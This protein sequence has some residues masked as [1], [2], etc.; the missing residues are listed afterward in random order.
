MPAP[1]HQ[2]DPQY[3]LFCDDFHPEFGYLCPTAGM[4]R[5]IRLSAISVAIGVTLGAATVLA[6]TQQ[7]KNC[8]SGGS[9]PPASVAA[10]AAPEAAPV[11]DGAVGAACRCRDVKAACRARDVKAA[12]DVRV[13]C[14]GR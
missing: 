12:R 4:R 3:H 13:A 7:G 6:L 11:S 1:N 8:D 14:R 5:R 10:V 2:R 9:A